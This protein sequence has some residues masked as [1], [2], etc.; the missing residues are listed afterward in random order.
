MDKIIWPPLI[1]WLLGHVV[2]RYDGETSGRRVLDCG[3]GGDRPPLAAFAQYG[4]EAHGIDVSEERL[5]RARAFCEREGVAADLRCADM[6]DLPFADGTF[7]FV[8]EHSSMC[9]LVKRDI[10]RTVVEMRR[11]LKAGGYCSVQFM[12]DDTRPMVGVEREAG[13]GEFWM[14]EG[15]GEI[16]HSVFAAEETEAYLAGLEVLRTAR[17]T[18][19]NA[20][21]EGEPVRSSRLVYVARKPAP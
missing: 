4:F 15:G 1:Y 13:S 21:A 14:E 17:W 10:S 6:R 8:Y 19:V 2:A 3:A 12:L 11:V 9:H 7:D 5:A 18:T 20:E 16:V